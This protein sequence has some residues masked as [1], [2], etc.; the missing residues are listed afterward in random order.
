MIV[1]VEERVQAR[2]VNKN[3]GGVQNAETPGFAAGGGGAGREG[4]IGEGSGRVERAES[5]RVGLHISE[6]V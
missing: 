1:V 6:E 4:R 3:V 5:I 2:P